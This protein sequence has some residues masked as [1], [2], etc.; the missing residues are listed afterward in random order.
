MSSRLIPL[1]IVAL[2]AVS[3]FGALPVQAAP[4]F[5]ATSP[6][7]PA[8]GTSHGGTNVT[9]TGTGFV[10][11]LIVKF[12]AKPATAISTTGTSIS[13]TTPSAAAGPVDVTI[14]NPDGSQAIF[15]QGF[16]YTANPV[17]TITAVS[18]SLGTALGNDRITLT[19]TGFSNGIFPVVKFGTV[20]AVVVSAEASKLV[21]IAPGQP[22]ATVD[23]KV[24]NPDNQEGTRTN[25]FT[26]IAALAP[27]LTGIVPITGSTNGGTVIT[28]TGTNLAAGLRAEFVDGTNVAPAASTI[29]VSPTQINLFTPAITDGVPAALGA[30][31]PVDIRVTNPDGQQILLADSFT[32]INPAS[33]TPPTTLAVTSV[34]PTGGPTTGGTAVI[35][36]GSGFAAGRALDVKFGGVSATQVQFVNANQIRAVAPVGI[37]GAVA[38]SVT[39]PDASTPAS[40]ANAFTYRAQVVI[41]SLSVSSVLT[42]GGTAV[43][44]TGDGF[45]GRSVAG[46]VTTLASTTITSATAAFTAADIGFRISGTGIPAGATITAIGSSTSATISAAATAA[47]TGVTFTL[48]CSTDNGRVFVGTVEATTT[49]CAGPTSITF[50]TPAL[51]AGTKDV[52]V[53][54]KSTGK[55]ATLQSGLSY[56]NGP[57]PSITLPLSPTS[58]DTNGGTTVTGAGELTITGTGFIPSPLPTV[59]VGTQTAKVL[60]ATSTQIK[61]YIPAIA[62]ASAGAKD[63]KVTNADGQSDTKVGAFTYTATSALPTLI[64]TSPTGGLSTG[65]ID[66]TLTGTNF[67]PGA[68]VKFGSNSVVLGLDFCSVSIVRNCAVLGGTSIVVVAPAVT[69]AGNQAV[70]V[71]NPNGEVSVAVV[72]YA[73]TLASAPTVTGVTP[74]PI[75]SN[76]REI[77]VSTGGGGLVFGPAFSVTVDTTVVPACSTTVVTNCIQASQITGGNTVMLLAPGHASGTVSVKVTNSDGQSG[78]LASAFTYTSEAAP[79]VT[80]VSPA[81]GFTGTVLTL[82]GTNF[83]VSGTSRLPVVKF[84]TVEATVTA[85]TATSLTVTVPTLTTTGLQ[86]ITITNPDGQS[87]SIGGQAFRYLA[88]PTAISPAPAF[89]TLNGGATLTLTATGFDTVAAPP[90]VRVGGNNAL[91]AKVDSN[92]KAT[93]TVPLSSGAA[94]LADVQV[95]DSDG[96]T[97]TLKSAFTYTNAVTSSFTSVTPRIVSSN[98]GT[99]VTIKGTG[100]VPGAFVCVDAFES[101]TVAVSNPCTATSK[102]RVVSAQ[103]VDSKTIRFVAPSHA[104]GPTDVVVTNPRGQ[105]GDSL[106]IP[107]T[108]NRFAYDQTPGPVLLSISP[109]SGDAAGGTAVTLTGANFASGSTVTFGTAAATG[110]VVVSSTRITAVTPANAAGLT[111]VTV[112]AGL[113]STSLTDAFTYTGTGVAPPTSTPT[114]TAA[115]TTSTPP[116][117]SG[118]AVPTLPTGGSNP[119]FATLSAATLLA[120]NKQVVTT[121]TRKGSSNEVSWTLPTITPAPVQGVQIWRSNSPYVLVTTLTASESAFQDG[122]YT[123]TSSEAKRGTDYLVT[124]FFGQTAAQGFLVCTV[125][126]SDCPN[127]PNTSVYAGTSSSAGFPFLT[128][129]FALIG[130]ALFF[131]VVAILVA[132]LRRRNANRPAAVEGW[133]DPG[134]GAWSGEPQP[135]DDAG[136]AEQHTLQCPAC[137][138]QFTAAGTRPL[139]TVCPG[140]NRTGILR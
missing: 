7:T 83:A 37:A 26:Y 18:P 36:T 116:A 27:T 137:Q 107:A 44:I 106:L 101:P 91:N 19:G 131:L 29:F 130:L 21:V 134:T 23:I 17:P 124:M 113:Q 80:A 56:L 86:L 28:L 127:A 53:V 111:L 92:T 94:G 31:S 32:F 54:L 3:L 41:N 119:C 66:V 46:G 67:R 15:T 35:I 123:D 25:A 14:I 90:V 135:T 38:V 11:G 24:T 4:A 79:A 9:I 103:V 52:T 1:A 6:I 97:V 40:L 70:T 81:N 110:V 104:A 140:C 78:T 95:V 114:A 100:F 76:G 62:L 82:T 105:A 121:V 88:I 61:V 96:Q 74:S 120:C 98:G 118:T 133:S 108:E 122:V 68:T 109:S 64:S 112:T 13:A 125:D 84:G 12:G 10:E 71:T 8:T 99:L 58:S 48:L 63:V 30:G 77:T 42:S 138:T 20:S 73:Y 72:N 50:T 33:A 139:T 16:T 39:N 75:G 85:A 60:S 87:T 5:A 117:T 2:L 45:G 59:L 49:T 69:A 89:D 55:S 65:G 51:V 115:P 132:A 43:T 57:A 47:G 136:N 129:F 102:D 128:L 93:A 34:T 22:P 126:Q